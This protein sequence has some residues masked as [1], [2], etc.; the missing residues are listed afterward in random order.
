MSLFVCPRTT[1]FQVTMNLQCKLRVRMA[2]E[3]VDVVI[4][5]T[6]DHHFPSNHECA[7]QNMH[8]YGLGGPRC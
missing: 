8:F 6:A 5:V 1:T 3:D 2:L 7:I 4:C